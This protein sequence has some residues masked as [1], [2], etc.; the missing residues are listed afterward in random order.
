LR[1]GWSVVR[2]FMGVLT[3][4]GRKYAIY[5][6]QSDSSWG[7]VPSIYRGAHGISH[8]NHLREWKKR[9]SRFASPIPRDDVDWLILA[10]H[11]GLA[12]AL[13]DWTTSPLVALYFA[14]DDQ[15]HRDAEGCVWWT[16]QSNF[17]DP[18]D[19]MTTSVFA[20]SRPK[21]ILINA[22]GRNVRSTAQDSFLSLHT[23]IDYQ[24]LDAEPIF[25]VSKR[26]KEPTL[27]ALEKLGFSGERLHFDI[28]MVVDRF[29]Q[30]MAG[31]RIVASAKP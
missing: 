5:R 29:K 30:E 28:T 25:R 9:A 4:K 27:V 31:R 13:L 14:C 24:T 23:P 1:S 21:P 22:V 11:Y 18:Y 17:E 20:P 19:T 8:Q 10:Q 12:T 3:R 7:L 15:K 2:D 6:G 26:M 16:M